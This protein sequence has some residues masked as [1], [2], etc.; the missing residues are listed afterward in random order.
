MARNGGLVVRGALMA[1]DGVCALCVTVES[2][3]SDI[4]NYIGIQVE[5]FSRRM[6]CGPGWGA[7]R[8]GEDPGRW[9]SW[10]QAR[11]RRRVVLGNSIE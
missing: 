4:C 8:E 3:A 1:N 9:G 11:A 7:G 2:L 5:S 10:E 6:A